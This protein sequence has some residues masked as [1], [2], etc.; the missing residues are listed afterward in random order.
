MEPSA[1]LKQLIHMSH[2]ISVDKNISINKYFN[3][4]RE[5]LKSAA[6]FEGKGDIE[7]AFILYLRYM[8]LFLEKIIHHPE[9]SKADPAEK[10][11]V[12]NECNKVFELAESL[13]TRIKEKYTRECELQSTGSVEIVEKRSLRPN[14][15]SPTGCDIDDIDRKFNFSQQPSDSQDVGF[16][17]F[18]IESLR[19]SFEVQRN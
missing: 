5:L 4:G 15:S 14:E 11:L 12:K 13:K 8:T 6:S 10:N 19:K 1:R 17:P 2:D 16:D 9:Y 3:S 18:N 7:R